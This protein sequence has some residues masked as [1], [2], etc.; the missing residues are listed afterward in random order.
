[1]EAAHASLRPVLPGYYLPWGGVPQGCALR[2]AVQALPPQ[3][4]DTSTQLGV[5][6]LRGA[7]ALPLAAATGIPQHEGDAAVVVPL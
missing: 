2:A 1:M 6:R 7:M 3:G 4:A 5:E